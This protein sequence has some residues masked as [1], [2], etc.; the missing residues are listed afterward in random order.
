MLRLAWADGAAAY[1]KADAWAKV[2]APFILKFGP[3]DNGRSLSVGSYE[4]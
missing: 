4:D 2:A 3:K 1:P